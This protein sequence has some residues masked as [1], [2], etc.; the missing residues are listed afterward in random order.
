MPPLPL[1][2]LR[3]GIAAVVLLGVLA[4]AGWGRPAPSARDWLTFGVLGLV[5]NAVFQ[6]CM[7]GG[8]R[9]TTPAHSALII[10]LNPVFAALLARAW[11]GERLG[12]RRGLGILLSLGG[13]ALVVTRG[14]GLGEAGSLLGDLLS[15]GAAVA[16]AVYAVVGKPILASRSPLE[17]TALAMVIGA[18]ALVPLGLPGLLA[19]GWAGLSPGAWLLLL[20]LSVITLV[21]SYLLWYW[22]LARAA[23][24][25]VVVFSYLSPVVAV[26]ISVAAG[27]EP[28]TGSLAAGGLAVIGG[29]ALAQRDED[30]RP[31]R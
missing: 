23:T 25:R 13:V 19:V 2:A 30:R 1:A 26:A 4:L 24:A 27:Q 11:L 14:Q 16:W 22:A 6:L 7:V 15:L 3:C 21:V 8:L 31:A 20:Y 28:L 29:V 12:L 5:G 9:L 18:V 17:V 10:T